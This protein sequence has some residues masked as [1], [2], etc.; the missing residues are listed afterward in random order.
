VYGLASRFGPT[1]GHGYDDAGV[2]TP[3]PMSDGRTKG[4]ARGVRTRTSVA[5]FATCLVLVQLTTWLGVGDAIDRVARRTFYAVRGDRPR[6]DR[7]LFVAVDDQTVA[8]WGEPP[9]PWSR[10]QVLVSRLRAGGAR[11][12][13]V[14]EPGPRIVTTAPVPASLLAEIAAGTLILP[15]AAPGSSQPRVVL[16]PAGSVEAIELGTDQPL[17]RSITA[18]VLRQLGV[19]TGTELDVNYIGAPDRLPT[20][21]AHLV[22]SGDIPASTFTGRVIVVGA[23]GVRFTALV[24]TPVGAMAPA[25]V[26]AHAID[27]VLGGA[28]FTRLSPWIGLAVIAL[29]ALAA[30]V[31]LRRLRSTT[32]LAATV[33]GAGLVVVVMGYAAFRWGLLVQVG[34]P[35]TAIVVA[36]SLGLMLERRDAV[37][38]MI[39]LQ[40]HIKHRL[41]LNDTAMTSASEPE[42]LAR[43]ADSLRT[44]VRNATCA[45]AELPASGWHLGADRW[46]GG[47]PDDVLERRR[48]V[49]RDPWRAPYASHRAEWANRPYLREELLVRTLLV[50]VVAFGRL[51]GFWI[52]SIPAR[53]PVA[54]PTLEAVQT[55][56]DDLAI[57]LSQHRLAWRPAEGWRA[58][59]LPGAV[60]DA[61]LATR[62]DAVTLAEAQDRTRAALDRLPIGVLGATSWGQVEH[63][64]RAMHD[65]LTTIGIAAA[66]RATLGA[67]IATLAGTTTEAAR[68]ALRDVSTAAGTLRLEVEL[69]LVD[70]GSARYDVVLTRVEVG[71][72]DAE[73]A[74]AMLVLTAARRDL[75]RPA[76]V[77]GA[78][79]DA[80]P[81]GRV[82]AFRR[83]ASED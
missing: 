39:D 69:E 13:A 14:L 20:L 56:S 40:R 30:I 54:A 6:S 71:D 51:L 29:I 35:L 24:P 7:L 23:R 8:A 28:A 75:A 58:P 16:D 44:H 18:D 65:F 53:Q 70:G 59:E 67:V 31:W 41:R 55:M 48:D 3:T 21:P 33:A 34:A 27:A 64:N 9:W 36:S 25:E 74:P 46:F 73:R 26:H 80:V 62:H 57:A 42:M 81:R 61:V 15:T 4:P 5:A 50:P 17:A 45:W 79:A 77:A 83:P 19:S 1:P 12:I 22:A 2:A 52:V 66:E 76:I 78:V 11:L 43:F 72:G 49:R 68:D 32:V 47:S 10:Y 82:I 38:G 60:V 63:C 37:Q